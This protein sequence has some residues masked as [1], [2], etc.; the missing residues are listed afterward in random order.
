MVYGEETRAFFLPGCFGDLRPNLTTPEGSFRGA[1]D[2]EVDRFG[3]RLGSEVVRV[4][5]EIVVEADDRLGVSRV[6][7]A[8]PYHPLPSEEELR[9]AIRQ[10]EVEPFAGEI[11]ARRERGE[12]RVEVQALR[13][14]P[15]MLIALPGEVMNEIGRGVEQDVQRSSI[16]MGYTNANPGYLCTARAMAERG[17]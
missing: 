8:L 2:A 12:A 4:A 1:T 9:Q 16:V 14:G 6:E 10:A 13:L 17:Y 5:E 7:L 11:L 3:R 15:I